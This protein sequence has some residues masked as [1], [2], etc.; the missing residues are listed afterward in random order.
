[1]KPILAASEF[2]AVSSCPLRPPSCVPNFF[3]RREE[4]SDGGALRGGPTQSIS[5]RYNIGQSTGFS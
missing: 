4:E 1:M 5:L 3:H 2:T